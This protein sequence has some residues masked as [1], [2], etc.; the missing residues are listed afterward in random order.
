MPKLKPL[1]WLLVACFL[2]F[3][4]FVVFAVTRDYYL[5]HP[6][7]P[8]LAQGAPAAPGV[9][10]GH[11]PTPA[12]TT[13]SALTE[14]DPD[15]LRQRAGA[16]FDEGRF[17]EAIPLYRRILELA[18]NDVETH[19]DLGLALYY[20]S[21]APGALAVLRTGSRLDP[22]AQRIWLTLGFVTLKSG[23]PAAAHAALTQ[24]RDLAPETPIGKEAARLLDLTQEAGGQ[25]G[26]GTS[27]AA[28]Q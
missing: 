6:L 1:H 18:A 15:R 12:D 22:R 5:R 14:T 10:A 7:R 20:T 23:D 3:Y 8:A 11:R 28:S 2:A 21:D 19:N 13:A 9:P 26:G 25:A 24:A 16:L 4:G 17:A 27:A